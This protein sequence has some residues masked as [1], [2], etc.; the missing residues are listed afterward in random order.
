MEI[1]YAVYSLS[2]RFYEKYPNPPYKELLKKKERGYACLLIQSHYGYFICIP[3]RT[4]ISHKYAYHFRKSSRSQK[5]R[6]GLD[7]TKIAIIKDI[8]YIDRIAII[9]QDEFAETRK[10][11]YYIA[12][13]A[14]QYIEEYKK[15]ISDKL[16]KSQLAKTQEDFE[17]VCLPYGC[18]KVVLTSGENGYGIPEL[19]AV[20]NEAVAA[21][22][23]D[24]EE[25]E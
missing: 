7:Y 13:K 20:L 4:E 12:E 6:S 9:D 17:K 11:I 8:S 10:H 24:D 23:T 14:E 15:H 18:Q 19:Q 25:A 16:K 1:D 3:Y 22:F 21:E 5:H 2:D